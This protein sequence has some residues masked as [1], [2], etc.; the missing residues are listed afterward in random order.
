MGTIG[1]TFILLG[2][3]MLYMMTGTL[4]IVD[5]AN[6]LALVGPN[7][8]VLVAAACIAVGVG[9]KLAVFPLHIWLPNAYTY[10]PAMVTAFIAATSTKVAYYVLV[11]FAY[12]VF[13]I[14][15][16]FDG[17]QRSAILMTLGI[18]AMFAGLAGGHLTRMTSSGCSPTHR[19]RRSATWF[20]V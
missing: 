9:I 14:N 15:L 6:Q 12:S 19:W 2:I 20:S 17:T 10:A 11:R 4:N 16:T 1:G 7:R 3:G 13:R 5:L 18:A 8:T